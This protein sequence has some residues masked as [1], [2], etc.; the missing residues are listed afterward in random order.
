MINTVNQPKAWVSFCMST[1]MRPILLEKTLRS[2]L[3]QTFTDFEVVISDNDPKGSAQL[4]FQ[5]KVL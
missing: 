4:G 3:S 2:I 1:Y 5:D